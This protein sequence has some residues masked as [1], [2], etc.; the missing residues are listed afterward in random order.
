M[1][2]G[3]VMCVIVVVLITV[4]TYYTYNNYIVSTLL[5]VFTAR[6]TYNI[7]ITYRENNTI[8]NNS[9]DGQ[10]GLQTSFYRYFI[11]FFFFI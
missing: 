7:I 4:N 1:F 10:N 6:R 2:N 8:S 5:S 9:I 11:L 3:I